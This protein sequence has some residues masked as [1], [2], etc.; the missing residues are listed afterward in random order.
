MCSS[1]QLGLGPARD[2][3][4]LAC[5]SPLRSEHGRSGGS[6]PCTPRGSEP[7]GEYP[8][9]LKWCSDNS[10]SGDRPP[11]AV[12]D[13]GDCRVGARKTA[14]VNTNDRD[15]KRQ[16]PDSRDPLARPNTQGQQNAKGD[17]RFRTEPVFS[18]QQNARK[19]APPPSTPRRC[20]SARVAQPRDDLTADLTPTTTTSGPSPASQSNPKRGWCDVCHSANRS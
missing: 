20:W 17:N 18:R 19:H 16:Q 3:T 13:R 10:F 5:S 2:L 4:V 9:T 7:A 6:A 8:K 15:G 11:R 1:N 12:R 14:S